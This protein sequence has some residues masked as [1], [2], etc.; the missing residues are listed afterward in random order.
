MKNKV[1]VCMATYNGD[2]F[3]EEQVAS[4]LTQINR[5]DELIISDDS[6]SDRTVEIIKLFKDSRIRLVVNPF[7]R[8]ATRNFENSLRHASGDIIFLADQDDVWY[9]DKVSVMTHYLQKYDLVVS[10]CNFID[11]ESRIIG[12]SFFAA[13]ASNKGVIKNFYKNSFLG[14]C[15]AFNRCVLERVLPF[16]EEIHQATQFKIYQDVWIGLLANILFKVKFIPQILSGFRRH[17]QNA[18]P[19]ELHTPSPQSLGSKFKGRL[20]LAVGLSKRVIHFF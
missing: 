9:P 3:I 15:M 11:S 12:E 18:S 6:S 2:K 8:S 16:P 13:Y 1:S 10:D 20:L 5:D 7:P 17:S 19:T 14:N 4:I